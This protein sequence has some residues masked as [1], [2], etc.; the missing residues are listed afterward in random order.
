MRRKIMTFPVILKKFRVISREAIASPALRPPGASLQETRQPRI[1][2]RRRSD[3]DGRA[4]IAT[5]KPLFTGI[6]AMV[7]RDDIMEGNIDT[8]FLHGKMA[9]T[10]Q[11]HYL[12]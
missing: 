8:V 3:F 5:A 11:T 9:N 4:D 7:V 1:R 12:P 10:D 6:S 2:P